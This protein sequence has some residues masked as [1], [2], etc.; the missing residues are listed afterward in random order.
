MAGMIKRVKAF[1]RFLVDNGLLFE[2]NRKVLHPLGLALIVDTSRDNRRRLAI[3]GL[4]ETDDEEGFLFDQETFEHGL[5][6]LQKFM[7]KT[8][9]I[10]I[11]NRMAK[12]GF[13]VQEDPD[14]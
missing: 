10:R 12:K 11:D 14:V 7:E 4:A 3:T 13:V 8:G 6:K 5:D 9:Q 1:E 2:I